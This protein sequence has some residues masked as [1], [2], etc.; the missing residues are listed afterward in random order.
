MAQ[1]KHYVVHRQLE[2]KWCATYIVGAVNSKH[3]EE[4]V[5]KTTGKTSLHAFQLPEADPEILL[6]VWRDQIAT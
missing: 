1:M 2:G 5:K 3:A 6:E 4:V